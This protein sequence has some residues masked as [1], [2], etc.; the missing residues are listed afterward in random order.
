MPDK[1]S[2]VGRSAR[3][4]TRLPSDLPR[5]A[6][7]GCLIGASAAA[8]LFAA[9]NVYTATNPASSEQDEPC[10]LTK[11][12]SPDASGRVYGFQSASEAAA[13][14]AWTER[15]LGGPMSP[16]YVSFRSA[17]VF[18]EPSG[19]LRGVRIPPGMDV[20]IGDTIDFT[21]GRRDPS[22]A[23]NFIPN[24]IARVRG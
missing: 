10:H 23:C 3:I 12:W 6:V 9:T 17:K 20:K 1:I 8:L 11:S 14:Q 7:S 15:D 18:V 5:L 4:A 19:H 24:L 22:T 16:R 2:S 13:S 21:A